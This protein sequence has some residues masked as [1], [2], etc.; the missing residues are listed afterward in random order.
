MITGM[1][2]AREGRI[3]LTVR[4]NSGSDREIEAVVDTGY[5]ESL[6]LPPAI[7]IALALRWKTFG[8]GTVADG[9]E[10]IFNRYVGILSW[11]G[12]DRRIAIDEMDEQPLVGMKLLRGFELRMQVRPGGKVTIKRLPSK[13]PPKRR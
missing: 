8:R 10:C 6:S 4:G 3:R 11:D 9:S 2:R 7:I 12:E 13:K 5:T 1:V